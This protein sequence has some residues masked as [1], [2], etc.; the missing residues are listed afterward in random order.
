[1]LFLKYKIFHQMCSQNAGNVISEPPILKISPEPPIR[2]TKYEP[3]PQT[4]PKLYAYV[5][6]RR[7][8]YFQ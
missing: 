7:L 3:P 5:C 4:K 6:T 8:D 2:V 1:M